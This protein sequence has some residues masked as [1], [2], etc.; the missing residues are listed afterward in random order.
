MATTPP[1]NAKP[2]TRPGAKDAPQAGAEIEATPAKK[3]GKMRLLLLLLPLLMAGGGAGWYFMQEPGEGKQA[4]AAPA[5]PPVFVTMEPFTVNLQHDE[6]LPQYLQVG[7]SL[8]LADANLADAIKLHMPEIRSRVLLL[9]SSKKAS[10]ISTPQ[11]K[12]AL[13]GE[14]LREIGQPLA[15]RADAKSVD[16]V[17]FTSFVIQ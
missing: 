4:K 8:K 11:G 17:L 6:T 15:G 10:D 3:S 7:L 9:L 12:T 1:K 13:S 14:L 16:S 2:D 5:K